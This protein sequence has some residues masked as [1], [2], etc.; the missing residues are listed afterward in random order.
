VW[1]EA[2]AYER[3][4]GEPTSGESLTNSQRTPKLHFIRVCYGDYTL[5]TG[6]G[7]EKIWLQQPTL[8]LVLSGMAKG[9]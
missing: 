7:F 8:V 9:K 4:D 2:T 3:Y 1:S 6:T 5:L